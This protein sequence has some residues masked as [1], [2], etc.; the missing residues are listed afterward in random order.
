MWYDE[1]NHC[2]VLSIVILFRLLTFT[3]FSLD[4][5]ITDGHDLTIADVTSPKP[6]IVTVKLVA[7]MEDQ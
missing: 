5:G 4:L 2:A 3:S 7:N 6:I 1:Q